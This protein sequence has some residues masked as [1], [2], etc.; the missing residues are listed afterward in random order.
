MRDKDGFGKAVAFACF[1]FLV[2]GCSQNRSRVVNDFSAVIRS[3]DRLSEA[4]QD[5]VLS[6]VVEQL[7]DQKGHVGEDK[8]KYGGEQFRSYYLELTATEEKWQG[9]AR[10]E[11]LRNVGDDLAFR[12]QQFVALPGV[13]EGDREKHRVRNGETRRFLRERISEL[14]TDTP[15]DIRQRIVEEFAR[16]FDLDRAARSGNYFHPRDLYPSA[17]SIRKKDLQAR[18]EKADPWLASLEISIEM[19]TQSP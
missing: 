9:P 13:T 12:V 11:Y 6:V 10:S 16:K 4:E 15:P 5:G 7:N 18:L 3:D 2:A 8:Q 1:V 17:F 19:I 14:Y